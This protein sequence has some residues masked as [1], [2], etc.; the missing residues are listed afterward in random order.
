MTV[1]S[2]NLVT[3]NWCRILL[4]HSVNKVL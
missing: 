4:P 3:R 1:R 2:R